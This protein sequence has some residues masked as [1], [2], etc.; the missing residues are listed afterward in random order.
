MKK[1]NPYFALMVFWLTFGLVLEFLLATKQPAYLAD[2]VRRE[3]WRLA[4]A[5]GVLMVV[6]FLLFDRQH[7]FVF[8]LHRKLAQV[9]LLLMPVGFLLGGVVTTETDPHFMILLA[10]LG[11]F[12]FVT[13]LALAVWAG[14]SSAGGHGQ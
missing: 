14:S 7:G 5:H 10:P 13:G 9:G 4:H 3:M 11:G 6:V 8:G 1:R 12:G 2:P